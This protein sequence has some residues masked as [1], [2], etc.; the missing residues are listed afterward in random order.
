MRKICLSIVCV[1]SLSVSGCAFLVSDYG[2]N[3]MKGSGIGAGVGAGLGAVTGG[4]TAGSLVVGAGLGAGI[5]AVGGAVY[6]SV[7][8][9]QILQENQDTIEANQEFIMKQQS[10]V[11]RLRE[12][13]EIEASQVKPDDSRKSNIYTDPTIGM[14]N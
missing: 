8:H 3:A 11:T 13:L 9:R 7:K 4:A 6:T 1:M 14:Y 12:E 2:A 5:G 10:D